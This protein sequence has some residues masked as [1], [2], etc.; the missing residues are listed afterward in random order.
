M[1]Y[2]NGVQ[3]IL[4][5]DV[6]DGV[7]GTAAIKCERGARVTFA[8]AAHMRITLRLACSGLPQHP[9]ATERFP[10]DCIQQLYVEDKHQTCIE[11]E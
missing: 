5:C 2:F 1:A 9:R 7:C 6:R 11:S 4:R 3:L 10:N 8:R